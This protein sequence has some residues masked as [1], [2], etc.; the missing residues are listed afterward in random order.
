M[1]TLH[2]VI[3]AAILTVVVGLVFGVA[4]IFLAPILGGIALIALIIWLLSRKARDKPPV[5]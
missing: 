5:P 3:V 4:G 1:R 2:W